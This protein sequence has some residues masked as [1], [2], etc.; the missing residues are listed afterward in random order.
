[1]PAT[2]P[3]HPQM[4]RRG[5]LNIMAGYAGPPG[6]QPLETTRMPPGSPNWAK[7]SDAHVQGSGNRLKKVESQHMWHSLPFSVINK[8]P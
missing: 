4:V 1:M 6:W 7:P 5:R 2:P 3:P 8:W